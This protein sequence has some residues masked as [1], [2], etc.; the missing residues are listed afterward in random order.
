MLSAALNLL[1]RT[2]V[3]GEKSLEQINGN[4]SNY[5]VDVAIEIYRNNYRGN[6]HDALA[7][8]YPVIKQ[9]VGDEFFRFLARKYIE[10]YPSRSANLHQYGE[11][12]QFLLPAE[13]YAAK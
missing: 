2:I 6:L 3:L 4:H 5:P 11:E 8:A 13:N 1:A 7:G 10:K 9:L 12:L